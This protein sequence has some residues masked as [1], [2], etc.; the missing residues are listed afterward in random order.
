MRFGVWGCNHG[1]I[2]DYIEEM[3]NLGHEAVGICDNET[4]K[5]KYYADMFG[6][7][8]INDAEELFALKPEIIGTSAVSSSKINIIEACETHGVHVIADKPA[9]TRL[10]DY[11]R[12]EKVISGG[13]IQIG[14]MLTARFA[15]TAFSLRN[16]IKQGRFGE[17]VSFN[18]Q[19]PHRLN[20]KKRPDTF[21][22]KEQNGS[23]IVDL[24]IHDF[25]LLRWFTGSEI[26]ETSGY[27]S[28]SAHSEYKSF[29]DSASVI[30]KMNNGVVATLETD[31]WI[32]DNYWNWG[33]GRISCVGTKGR[34]EIRLEGNSEANC[35]TVL[36]V[37]DEE[38]NKEK[39]AEEPMLVNIYQ[40]FINRINGNLDNIITHNDILK[41]SY[42]SLLADEK[43][44]KVNK[45]DRA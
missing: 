26:E 32:P 33:D 11:E 21:F 25:D 23:L 39:Y 16:L 12:L 6:L 30:V 1:H 37:T 18:M 10:K 19:S 8:Y 15:P 22:S 24:L 28:K 20:K 34:A 42:A 17:I 27:I 4:E 43:A 40:D 9:V 41:S 38:G 29:Y 13:R 7:P 2:Y 14:L 36:I 44:M 3:L 31:W 5:G 45:T 35:E